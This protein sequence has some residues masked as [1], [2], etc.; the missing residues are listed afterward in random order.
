MAL[1]DEPWK[2][3]KKEKI[4]APV[5]QVLKRFNFIFCFSSV[6]VLNIILFLCLLDRASRERKK[7][8]YGRWFNPDVGSA[9]ILRS[10]K[11]ARASFSRVDCVY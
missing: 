6:S 9:I 4:H 7:K 11:K 1:C 8:G 10:N 5:P 3:K 2:K